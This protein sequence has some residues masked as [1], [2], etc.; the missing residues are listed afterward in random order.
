M[1]MKANG[2]NE[3]WLGGEKWRKLSQWRK[4]VSMAKEAA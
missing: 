3:K 4:P 2:G 1:K